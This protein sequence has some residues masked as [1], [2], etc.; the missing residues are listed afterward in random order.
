MTT[1]FRCAVSLQKIDSGGLTLWRGA[2]GSGKN[3]QWTLCMKKSIYES[4]L[5]GIIVYNFD[6]IKSRIPAASYSSGDLWDSAG[7]H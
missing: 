3:V 6:C 5:S 1:F 4:S 2:W 7:N